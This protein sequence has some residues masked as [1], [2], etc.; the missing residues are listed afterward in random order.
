MESGVIYF[1]PGNGDGTFGAPQTLISQPGIA[2]P[3]AIG[4]IN[5]DGNPDI[6]VPFTSSA[7]S[8][9]LILVS[10]ANGT[11]QTIFA[12]AVLRKSFV[13]IADIDGDGKG[14]LISTSSV[15]SSAT[16]QI[17][18]GDGTF[19]PPQGFDGG[20]PSIA[21]T[22]ADVNHDGKPDILV[23]DSGAITVLTNE[24]TPA[25]K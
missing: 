14:D 23:V 7:Q 4:D 25:L 2:P 18:N 19:Q 24:T 21:L 5:G 3:L 8:E 15:S 9:Y 11:F 16:A 12:P 1:V 22:I 20:Y 17:G 10:N 13:A 6:I